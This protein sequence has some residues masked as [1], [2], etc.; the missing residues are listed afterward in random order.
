[1]FFIS[2]TNIYCFYYSIYAALL[3]SPHWESH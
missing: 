3:P 2:Y 1:M